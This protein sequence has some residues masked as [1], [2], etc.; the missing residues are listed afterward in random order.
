MNGLK[1]F[2]V[3]FEPM[4]PV[5]CCL[6]IAAYDESRAN[7]IASET[8]SHTDEFVVSEVIVNE[9]MVIEYLDGNY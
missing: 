1:I 3:Y 2:K 7:Q 4:Y 8:I 9:P 6:I 5:G